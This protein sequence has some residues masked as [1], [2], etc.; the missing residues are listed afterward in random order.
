MLRFL[1]PALIVLNLVL[2]GRAMGWLPGLIG[3]MPD[4]GRISRQVNPEQLKI[5]PPPT[6]SRVGG[7]RQ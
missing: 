1:I 2:F 7:P 4:P 5:L 3:D 6:G